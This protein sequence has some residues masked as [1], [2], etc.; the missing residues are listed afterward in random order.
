MEVMMYLD[1]TIPYQSIKSNLLEYLGH[2]KAKARRQTWTSK[3]MDNQS[4]R[5][6]LATIVRNNQRL[7]KY[8]SSQKDF[9]KELFLGVLTLHYSAE[10]CHGLREKDTQ[11]VDQLVAELEVSWKSRPFT[12]RIRMLQDTGKPG[13]K[14]PKEPVIYH[15]YSV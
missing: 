5:S 3:P 8:L 12:A 7:S 6:F 11:T 15:L 1:L 4:P 2:T 10:V 9:V 14:R 13:M